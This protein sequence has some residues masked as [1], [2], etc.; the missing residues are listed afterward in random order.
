MVS[1][2]TDEEIKKIG[3]ASKIVAIVLETL[4]ANVRE[5]MSTEDVNIMAE[6]MLVKYKAKPAFKGYRGYPASICVSIND[7]IVHGIPSP[8]R[9]I[10]EG[11]IVSL[12]F[13]VQ[14]DGFFGDAAITIPIGSVSEIAQRLLKI[15]K[16]SLL[17]GIK[18]AKVGNR[19]YDISS[20]IQEH[21]EKNGFSVVRDFV[22]H[23]I[24]RS[25]HEEPQIPNYGQRGKGIRLEKGMVFAIEPMIN[26]GDYRIKID[27]DGWTA[28]TLDGSLSAHFEHTI[29]VDY[30]EGKIL[31]KVN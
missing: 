7:E 4:A 20:A 2:K 10:K 31:S 30:E 5:G 16:E 19:L 14:L 15:T 28:R 18:E 22:G 27:P 25:L 24:G 1:V 6:Q 9:I 21:A 3:E 17:L 29:V 26:A 8:D 12:D 11:D 23:G 13:G